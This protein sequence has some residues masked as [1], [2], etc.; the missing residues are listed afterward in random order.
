M[1]P[2]KEINFVIKEKNKKGEEQ[3]KG[4]EITVTIKVHVVR[5]S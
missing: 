2:W 1:G 3:E 4:L 5:S